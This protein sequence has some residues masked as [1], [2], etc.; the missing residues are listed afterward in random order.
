M[1]IYL[2]DIIVVSARIF[3][4]D[5]YDLL[6][7]MPAGCRAGF[8]TVVVKLYHESHRVTV[9][10]LSLNVGVCVKDWQDK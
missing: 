7:S 10:Q 8:V 2:S 4:G 5:S 9:N 3:L 1:V 6:V